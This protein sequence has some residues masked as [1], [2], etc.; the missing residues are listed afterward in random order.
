MR[1]TADS[2]AG[3]M[4]NLAR[5]RRLGIAFALILGIV[6]TVALV[7]PNPFDNPRMLNVRFDESASLGKILRTV[8]VNGVNVGRIADVQRV[9]DDAEFVLELTEDIG[10][11]HED[12]S[13]EL[14][15]HIIF[16][17]TVFVDL[18]PG[19][20]DAPAIGPEGIPLAQTSVFVPFDV[21]LRPLD[22]RRRSDIRD[23]SG[24]L[25][26]AL[27]G[28]A[29]G[30]LRE[31]LE[32]SPELLE[33]GRVA[34][35]A[36][37][38]SGGSELREGLPKLAATI[39]SVAS[40]DGR[41]AGLVRDSR[42]TFEAIGTDGTGPLD[43]TLAELEP[44]LVEVDLGSA[45]LETVLDRVDPLAEDL[46]PALDELTPA[47]RELRPLLARAEPVL[48][49]ADPL[50]RDL[51]SA[52]DRT[53]AAAPETVSVLDALAPSLRRLDESIA[54]Y[55]YEKNGLGLPHYMQVAAFASGLAGVQRVYQTEEQNPFGGG[56]AGLIEAS[57]V[58]PVDALPACSLLGDI[59][60]SLRDTLAG[61]GACTP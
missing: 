52:V 48:K 12:A 49:R 32:N 18:D 53:A 45:A 24:D 15:P 36:A 47:L 9:G 21:A 60:D 54:P 14:R 25:A 28:A 22:A 57:F 35:R 39:R 46:E 19:S 17:G 34:A 26:K 6:L 37:R 30:G 56:R 16:E 29:I 27:G 23:L 5:L 41:I 61:L 44:T 50:A 10:V 1:R 2:D 40:E 20:E 38:G 59:S 33:K 51:R 55:L 58:Q 42:R 7:A 11:I 4:T 3:R 13:A 31:T 8:R 43:R